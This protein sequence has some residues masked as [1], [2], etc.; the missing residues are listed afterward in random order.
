MYGTD[1]ND[2]TIIWSILKTNGRCDFSTKI[3]GFKKKS[4]KETFSINVKK[5]LS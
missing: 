1:T 5:M 3:S 4:E 2:D